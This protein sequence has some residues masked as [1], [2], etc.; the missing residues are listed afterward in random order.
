MNRINR[1]PDPL[2]ADAREAL[3]NYIG[4]GV[5]ASQVVL[6]N[7]SDGLIDLII[8]TFSKPDGGVVCPVPTF[9]VY[10]Q[11]ARIMGR[12]PLHVDRD[13]DFSVNVDRLFRD[14]ER[15]LAEAK[16]TT[17]P[18]V[19]FVANPNNPTGNLVP[20][21]T[22]EAILGRTDSLVVV[23]ECYYEMCEETV[24]GLVSKYP[25]L[26]VLRSFS[27]SFGLAGLRIGY[28]FGSEVIA[29]MLMR[30][31]QT[32]P[33]NRLAVAAALAA[34][35]DLAHVRSWID[36]MR[37]ERNRLASELASLGLKVYPSV[38]NFLLVAWGDAYPS[39]VDLVNQIREKGVYV[40][41]CTGM[42]GIHERCF[43]SS[44]GT[45]EEN[46]RL[47]RVIS[48]VLRR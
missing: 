16:T 40:C 25:N 31:D 44:V 28:C 24:A 37:K 1:Y 26:L 13:G 27:K 7:G 43:R 23:D 41:D 9:F 29:D 33:V 22:I 38:T 35:S 30:A 18:H 4:C 20:T 42:P 34:L 47:A 32:F 6:G 12:K 17:G 15:C 3:A 19:M 45:R 39:C 10:S 36:C 21:K 48:T 8:K 5:R 46:G 11:A 14:V 2:Y